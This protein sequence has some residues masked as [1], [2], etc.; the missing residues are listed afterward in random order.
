MGQNL[1]PAAAPTAP[2]APPPAKTIKNRDGFDPA[3]R[4]DAQ[5]AQFAGGDPVPLQAE[6]TSSQSDWAFEVPRNGDTRLGYAEWV[7]SKIE[8]ATD[9]RTRP[10]LRPQTPQHHPRRFRPEPVPSQPVAV[11]ESVPDWRARLRP[12][13]N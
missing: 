7:E 2:I 12:Q 6:Y 10:I 3:A 11:N 8:A 9:A 5:T 4:Q 13:S 1:P